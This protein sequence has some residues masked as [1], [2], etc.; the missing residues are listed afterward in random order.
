MSMD[1]YKRAATTA[2]TNATAAQAAQQR[3]ITPQDV[4]QCIKQGKIDMGY[5]LLKQVYMDYIARNMEAPQEFIRLHAE[6]LQIELE[7]EK[8]KA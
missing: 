8:N 4:E 5:A 3:N 6:L 2:K 7:A 1:K